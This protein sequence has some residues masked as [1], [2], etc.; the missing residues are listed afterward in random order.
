MFELSPNFGKNLV[1]VNLLYSDLMKYNNL[2]M[3]TKVQLINKR[4]IWQKRQK[5]QKNNFLISIYVFILNFY[6]V[7]SFNKIYHYNRIKNKL[8][9]ELPT[10][11][12]L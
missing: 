3:V 4:I 6:Y 1:M 11:N 8:N 5:S 9:I 7:K 2:Y 10:F 12:S